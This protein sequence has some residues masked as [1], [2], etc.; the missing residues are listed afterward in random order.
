MSNEGNTV[1]GILAGTAIGAVLG[2]LFAPD[3]GTNTRKKISDQAAATQESLT[4]SALDIKDRLGQT[5]AEGK[6]T[7]ETRVESLV[8]DASFK[9]ED[10]I[11]SLEKQ[12]KTLKAKNRQ[13]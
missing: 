7:L 6:D 11:S 8:S 10:V 2:I 3:K 12:L 5:L 9:T 1:L 13:L 4:E